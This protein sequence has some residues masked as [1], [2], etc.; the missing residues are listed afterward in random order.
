MGRR[1]FLTIAIFL[2]ASLTPGGASRIG[3]A[4]P[5]KTSDLPRGTIVI[6][7]GHGGIDGGTSYGTVL[8]KDLVLDIALRL[9]DA[10]RDQGFYP[11]LTRERDEDLSTRYPSPHPSRHAR[12]LRNRVRTAEET[13][14][15]LFLSIHVNHS[16]S[17]TRRG[18][19][20]LYAAGDINGAWLA[21]ITATSLAGVTEGRASSHANR[22]LYVLRRA[23]CPAILVEVGFLSNPLERAALLLPEYRQQIAAAL[24]Q[25]IQTYWLVSPFPDERE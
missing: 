23:P 12:D 24:C 11:V 13:G 15:Q 22:S 4:A 18:A 19:V 16:F 25:A 1:F 14:A 20:V 10:L 7:P 21:H 6:D 8:E 9:R 2:L 5:V 17:A 3:E